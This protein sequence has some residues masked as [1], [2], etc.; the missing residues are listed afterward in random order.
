MSK[1]ILKR[2]PIQAPSLFL[3]GFGLTLP[4]I[5]QNSQLEGRITDA[6][7]SFVGSAAVVVTRTDSGLKQE[8]VSNDQ[9]Y[10]V[11]PLLPPGQYEIAV[12][13]SGF[14]PLTRTGIV[15]ETAVTTTVDLRLEVGGVNET[16]IVE[17]AAPLLQPETSSVADVVDGQSIQD[18]PLVDRRAAQ[19]ADTVVTSPVVLS[20]SA[21]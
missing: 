9:G 8:V 16:V 2:H 6:S 18:L 12:T 3:L 20:A 10:Y 17:A 4:A 11:V 19:L 5:A 7:R 15:L 13:K 14:K 1:S 21:W